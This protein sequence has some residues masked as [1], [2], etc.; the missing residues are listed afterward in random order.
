VMRCDPPSAP[1]V[2]EILLDFEGRSVP[3]R[4]GESVAAALT[5]DG[6]RCL[7]ITG[8]GD[9]R[10]VFCGMGVCHDC[11]V[12]IDGQA[13]IRACM[14]KVS[15]PHKIRRQP[16]RAPISRQS[17]SID[18]I[19][20][21]DV[22][23]ET[24]DIAVVGGGAGGLWAAAISAEAGANVLLID[25][26]PQLGG[27][28]YKQAA[29]IYGADRSDAQFR[30]GAALIERVHRANVRVMEATVWG[31]F[32]ALQLAAI[33]S[34]RSQTI[35]ASR[36]IVATGAYERVPPIDGWTLPGVMTTGAAQTFLRTYRVVPGRRILIA[37]NGPLNFQVARELLRAGAEVV[38]VA[39]LA[40]RPRF[41]HSKA[42]W[43]MLS[44]SPTLVRNGVL[45]LA[46]LRRRGVPV[47]YAH[48]LAKIIQTPN[49]LQ[50]RLDQRGGGAFVAGPE[51]T[52]DTV[53]MGYG[54][55][56]SNEI[57][58]ALGASQTFDRARG[59]LVT[60]RD[61]H[62]QTSV[63]GLYGVG[64]CCG[65][66]GAQAAREEGVIAATA[67]LRSLGLSLQ[68]A[69]AAAERTSRVRLQ[70][71]L[72]FQKGLWSLFSPAAVPALPAPETLICRC[73]QVSHKQ[74]EEV[75]AEGAASI[76]EVKRQ[77]RA[78]MGRCQGRYCA[79]Q[80][81]AL[82]AERTNTEVS[83]EALF[84]PRPPIKPVRISDL[85]YVEKSAS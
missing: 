34:Q 51:F 68:P 16:A 7:R 44:A 28:F 77:T 2:P 80:L 74:I 38:A 85:V 20:A 13:N 48:R 75:L 8:S 84:A 32:P 22:A 6:I 56:P 1:A 57:L 73:E 65:L 15:G 69:L 78:G 61:Q 42:L 17:R 39:E 59:H 36:L 18:A 52:V 23:I 11:L 58:R 37:G 70:R 49:G 53:L 54:F 4:I 30:D 27:Q 3:A 81:A 9:M 40:P 62:C 19:E 64:D 43:S 29:A 79:L 67:A 25:E 63:A 24:P 21:R 12:E 33:A 60:M 26:R 82:I 45:Y 72:R 41:S 66:S 35:H 71:C 31:A 5:S 10:G 83:E 50:A 46:D 14:T 76:G 55:F 47:L